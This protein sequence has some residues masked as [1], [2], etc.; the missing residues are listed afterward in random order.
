M[1]GYSLHVLIRLVK[2][3]V[4]M[5]LPACRNVTK[6]NTNKNDDTDSTHS[7]FRLAFNAIW[8]CLL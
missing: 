7:V 8:K 6:I 2:I 4:K 3:L 5:L 1:T